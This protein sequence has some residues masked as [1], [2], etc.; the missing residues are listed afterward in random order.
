MS[1]NEGMCYFYTMIMSSKAD[2]VPLGGNA[3]TQFA[4]P[5]AVGFNNAFNYFEPA[6]DVLLKE[7]RSE[8]KAGMWQNSLRRGPRT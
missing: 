3:L 8:I 1:E 4:M 5:Y 6:I 7:L 2:P